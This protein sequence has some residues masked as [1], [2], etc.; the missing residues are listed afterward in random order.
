MGLVKKLKKNYIFL[1]GKR[2]Q[3]NVFDDLL[4]RKKKAFLDYNNKD[5]KKSKN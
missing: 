2:D 5:L 3:E 1:L 4:E